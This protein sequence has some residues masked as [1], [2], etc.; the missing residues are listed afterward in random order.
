MQFRLIYI[1]NVGQG[2]GGLKKSSNFV[3]ENR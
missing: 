1:K 3:P 2:N